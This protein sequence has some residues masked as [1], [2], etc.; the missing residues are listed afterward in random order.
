VLH[1]KGFHLG[2]LIL[3]KTLPTYLLDEVAGRRAAAW[4]NRQAIW[5]RG[6]GRRS[7]RGPGVL[8]RVLQEVGENFRNLLVV[9]QREAAERDDLAAIP[10]SWL[11]SKS[12]RATSM[13]S[14]G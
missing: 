1:D 2:G 4:W 13:T 11:P 10:R 3:N 12:S 9:A 14:P 8:E 5:P 6:P 7:G